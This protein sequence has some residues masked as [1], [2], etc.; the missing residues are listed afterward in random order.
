[1][2]HNSLNPKERAGT[3]CHDPAMQQERSGGNTEAPAP[4]GTEAPAA[5]SSMRILVAEDNKINQLVLTKMLGKQGHRV[6]LAEN[7]EEAV[8]L[9][10]GHT[11]D[12]IFMDVQMP[13]MN[14]F[15]ASRIIRERLGDACPVLIA[16]T[17]NALPGDR[18]RCL[19]AGMDEYISKPITTRMIADMLC[20]F[21]SRASAAE[22]GT[23]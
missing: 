11:Y 3:V 15:D 6:E 20:R 18:E 12:L 23:P 7:G 21:D 13:V 1:M 4:P 19:E 9:A 10:L 8:E 5:S 2:P 14:G 16:V 22:A 17:A